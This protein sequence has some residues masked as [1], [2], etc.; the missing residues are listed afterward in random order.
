MCAGRHTEILRG[1]RDHFALSD[2]CC[3][4]SSSPLNDIGAHANPST[5][6]SKTGARKL[7]K[8]PKLPSRGQCYQRGESLGSRDDGT[9]VHFQFFLI[10]VHDIESYSKKLCFVEIIK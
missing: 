1:P 8:M 5:L 2:V 9:F 4:L 10:N 6:A 7:P 3:F